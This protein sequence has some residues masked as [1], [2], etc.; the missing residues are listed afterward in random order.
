MNLNTILNVV[1]GT[2]AL[3]ALVIGILNLCKCNK[4]NVDT[5][6]LALKSRKP[7][8]TE[9]ESLSVSDTI[10]QWLSDRGIT[11]DTGVNIKKPLNCADAKFSSVAATGT[12]N[13]GDMTVTGTGSFGTGSFGNISSSGTGSFET[14]TATGMHV[15]GTGMFSDL[16]AAVVNA[17]QIAS[18]TSAGDS[19]I[20]LSSQLISLENYK[21][22]G[23]IRAMC[24]DASSTSG[25]CTSRVATLAT[26]SDHGNLW[27][28]VGAVRDCLKPDTMSAAY[29][30]GQG[31]QGAG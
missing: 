17:D 23:M 31:P 5:Q 27:D 25:Y 14:V 15:S 30:N 16:H 24:Y 13:F 6:F 29:P 1:I 21:S 2:I 19:K 9:L 18:L 26:A 7:H 28:E 4:E 3:A 22:N 12:G 20:F 8:G 10:E 11:F